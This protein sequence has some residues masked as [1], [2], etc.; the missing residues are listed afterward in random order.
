MN[1]QRGSNQAPSPAIRAGLSVQVRK[2]KKYM[3]GLMTN[4]NNF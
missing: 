1:Y 4:E 3:N 2:I